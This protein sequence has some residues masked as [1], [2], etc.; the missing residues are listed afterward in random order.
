MADRLEQ[1][2]S[3][4]EK[5]LKKHTGQSSDKYL[6][7]SSLLQYIPTTLDISSSGLIV[8]G[9]YFVLMFMIFGG[10]I[11]VMSQRFSYQFWNKQSVNSNETKLLGS[12]KY[13]QYIDEKVAFEIYKEELSRLGDDSLPRDEEENKSDDEQEKHDSNKKRPIHRVQMINK[14]REQQIAYEKYKERLAIE[15]ENERYSK[16]KQK[17]QQKQSKPLKSKSLDKKYQYQM[18]ERKEKLKHLLFGTWELA[19]QNVKNLFLNR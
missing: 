8:I 18:R 19:I 7:L 13:A 16:I 4:F 12:G 11:I 9:L 10:I 5:L 14:M 15:K 2:F 1:R 6:G 17:R 3:D